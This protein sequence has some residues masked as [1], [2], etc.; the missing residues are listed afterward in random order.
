MVYILGLGTVLSLYFMYKNKHSI[1]FQLLKYYTYADEYF[2]QNYKSEE[3]QLIYFDNSIVETTSIINV[4]QT[5]K[6]D[7]IISKDFLVLDRENK[8][9]ITKTLYTI[10]EFKDSEIDNETINDIETEYTNDKENTHDE[11]TGDSNNVDINDKINGINTN[12]NYQSLSIIKSIPKIYN[13]IRFNELC[14]N[15]EEVIFH[16]QIDLIN[17]IMTWD[18]PII[19]TTI[20]IEDTT[21]V[22]TFNEYDITDFFKG[23]IR[24]NKT[25]ILNNENNTKLLW[26]IIFNYVF[27]D[28]N[29]LIPLETIPSLTILWNIIFED[30][31]IYSGNDLKI[32]IK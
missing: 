22:Y 14:T 27:K 29:L 31:K 8:N 1:G 25:V 7:Y 18:N 15:C 3:T 32:D 20:C 16:N 30:G 24:P 23:L 13:D 26:I 4:L 12:K 10:Y 5:N 6:Q 28:K 19:A 17:S 21:N 2:K 9:Q 11:V